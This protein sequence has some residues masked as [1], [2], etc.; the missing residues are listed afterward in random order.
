MQQSAYHHEL[1]P[2]ETVGRFVFLEPN[3]RVQKSLN[4]YEALRCLGLQ[5]AGRGR[6]ALL[7]K[8]SGGDQA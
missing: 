6:R 8:A 5:Q 3:R 2:Q 4:A 1:R 7:R